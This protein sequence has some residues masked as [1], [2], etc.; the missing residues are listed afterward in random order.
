[1]QWRFFPLQRYSVF[2]NILC[3]RACVLVGGCRFL[4][5][6]SV[7]TGLL[8]IWEGAVWGRVSLVSWRSKLSC[9]A[10]WIQ[11]RN[12]VFMKVNYIGCINARPCNMWLYMSQ[13]LQICVVQKGYT[14]YKNLKPYSNI[15]QDYIEP[16]CSWF[17][18]KIFYT[19]LVQNSCLIKITQMLNTISSV[20]LAVKGRACC[21]G[22][23]WRTCFQFRLWCGSCV[24]LRLCIYLYFVGGLERGP[25]SIVRTIEELFEWN[26]SGSGLENRD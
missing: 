9:I 23:K 16:T 15:L 17:V 2:C 25:L 8:G 10:E 26:S 20:A 6:C 1:V 7:H 18:Q 3:V 21:I 5:E 14:H 4:R 13:W 24:F 12:R 19:E 11:E 22:E